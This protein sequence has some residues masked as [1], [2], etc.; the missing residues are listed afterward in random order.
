MLKSIYIN[1]NQ[2][3]EIIEIPEKNKKLANVKIT[4]NDAQKIFDEHVS[5]LHLKL[6]V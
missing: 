1:K 3:S 2:I 6:I 5:P 4:M